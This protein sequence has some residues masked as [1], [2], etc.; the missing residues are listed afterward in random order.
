M[1]TM[2]KSARS[3]WKMENE[4][5]KTLKSESNGHHFEHNHGHG[6]QHLA[7]VMAPL[8][9]LAFLMEQVRRKCM[10]EG[11]AAGPFPRHPQRLGNPF[12]PAVGP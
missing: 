12:P 10:R 7:S 9:M 11:D 2:M 3:R 5:F 1:M 8:C 6:K 4:T